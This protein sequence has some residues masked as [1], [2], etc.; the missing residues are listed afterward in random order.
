MST[1]GKKRAAGVYGDPHTGHLV[2]IESESCSVAQRRGCKAKR[3][4]EKGIYIK[5]KS[6]EKTVHDEARKCNDEVNK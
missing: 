2:R 1:I 6:A 4:A 5:T 3:P